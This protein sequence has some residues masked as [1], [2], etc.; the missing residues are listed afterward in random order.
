MK[1][2]R[3]TVK[4]ETT[5]T[6]VEKKNFLQIARAATTENSIFAP[7]EGWEEMVVMQYLVRENTF[8]KQGLQLV[9]DLRGFVD[10]ATRIRSFPAFIRV[11]VKVAEILAKHEAAMNKI[12]DEGVAFGDREWIDLAEPFKVGLFWEDVGGAPRVTDAVEIKEKEVA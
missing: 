9:L 8:K 3:K 6:P 1:C 4:P 10:G 12:T 2:Q 5:V 11:S 7:G